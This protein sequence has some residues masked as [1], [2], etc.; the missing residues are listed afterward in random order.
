MN[1]VWFG[2]ASQVEGDER[3]VRLR[4]ALDAGLMSAMELDR[5]GTDRW[6]VDRLGRGR[7]RRSNRQPASDR[8]AASDGGT[9]TQQFAALQGQ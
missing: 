8:G 1:V 5:F 7:G 9:T 6:R 4:F 3:L 2:I